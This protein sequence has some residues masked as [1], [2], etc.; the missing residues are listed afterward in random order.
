MRFNFP[1]YDLRIT[2]GDVAL[3]VLALVSRGIHKQQLVSNAVDRSLLRPSACFH[4]APR[5]SKREVA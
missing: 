3:K 1:L 4:N 5:A 2:N